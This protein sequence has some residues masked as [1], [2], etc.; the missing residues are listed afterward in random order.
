M[1]VFPAEDAGWSVERAV[2]EVGGAFGDSVTVLPVV[3]AVGAL[4][5][6]SLST[7]LAGFAVF[8]VVWGLYYGVPVSVEP[9]KAL[10][11]LA[12]AAALRYLPETPLPG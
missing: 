4:S 7:A 6:L 2:G 10:A 5:S 8:Q 1:A 9:M 12:I 11:A 3:V